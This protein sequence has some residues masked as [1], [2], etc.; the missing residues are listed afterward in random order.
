MVKTRRGRGR[1]GKA[2]SAREVCGAVCAGVIVATDVVEAVSVVIQDPGKSLC[3]AQWPT[4]EHAEGNQW[5]C[6]CA[7]CVPLPGT[8]L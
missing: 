6:G 1:Y 2:T 8:L 7:C 4:R 5:A 3:L